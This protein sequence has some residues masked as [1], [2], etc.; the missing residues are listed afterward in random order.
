MVLNA[1]TLLGRVF[2]LPTILGLPALGFAQELPI[3][4]VEVTVNAKTVPRV[5]A[6]APVTSPM[7]HVILNPLALRMF[8]LIRL[9]VAAVMFL[10]S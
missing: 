9:I 4:F 3:M 2:V 5:T 7:P 1:T 8:L 6:L 10:A